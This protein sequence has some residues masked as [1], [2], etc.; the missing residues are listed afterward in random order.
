MYIL[1]MWM[2]YRKNTIFE[3]PSFD[4]IISSFTH[5]SSP[6]ETNL[7]EIKLVLEQCLTEQLPQT[8]AEIEFEYNVMFVYL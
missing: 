7:C 8:Q 5:I 6:P 1:Y 3:I 4:V 2:W